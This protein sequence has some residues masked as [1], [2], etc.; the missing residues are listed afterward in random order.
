MSLGLDCLSL[1]S[2]AITK[3]LRLRTFRRR[4]KDVYSSTLKVES[5]RSGYSIHLASGKGLSGLVRT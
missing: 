1:L 3:C 2:V 4:K 5:P